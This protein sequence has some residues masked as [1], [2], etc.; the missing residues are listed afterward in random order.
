MTGWC[1]IVPRAFSFVP[2][3]CML[4]IGFAGYPPVARADDAGRLEMWEEPSH[5]LVF[6]DGPSRLLDVRIAPGVT[7]EFHKHRFATTYVIIQDALVANQFRGGEWGA[8]GPR[9][10]RQAGR[11]V[12][13]STYVAKPTYHRVR[14]EDQR[15]FHVFAVI[16]ERPGDGE[17]GSTAR[18]G[19]DAPIDN[20][21]FREYRIPVAGKSRSGKQRFDN[22]VVLIQATAGLSHVIEND[23]AH[24]FKGAPAAFSWHPA[25]TEFQLVN[26]SAQAL[27][28]VLIEVKE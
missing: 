9:G 10:Y 11:T 5:Q 26:R 15:A 23:V 17:S 28:F 4:T 8:S 7:S 24:S 3:I 18:A 1:W 13:N 6:V 27:E 2:V 20:Q 16:N 22:D 19:N 21:W 14:N 25:G 12:D